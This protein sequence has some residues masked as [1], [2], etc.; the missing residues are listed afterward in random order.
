MKL[1]KEQ[2]YALLIEGLDDPENIGYVPHC[3]YVGDLAGM[4]AGGMGLDPEYA[5]A[6][7]EAKRLRLSFLPSLR[8]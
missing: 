8:R 1:T 5:T 6:R 3:R 7:S 2:A 4:I